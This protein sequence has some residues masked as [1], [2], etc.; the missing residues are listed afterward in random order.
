M[1]CVI[2]VIQFLLACSKNEMSSK[3]YV[4]AMETHNDLP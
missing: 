4:H 1:L 3:F 2:H